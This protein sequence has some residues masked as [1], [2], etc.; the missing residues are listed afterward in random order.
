MAIFIIAAEDTQAKHNLAALLKELRGCETQRQFAKRLQ[1][2]YTSIQDWEKEIRLPSEKNLQRIAQLKGWTYLELVL[3]LFGNDA[4]SAIA[5]TDPLELIMS[6]L[7]KLSSA[8]RQNLEDSLTGNK[9]TQQEM[10]VDNPL[11]YQL[12]AQEKHK[13]HLLLRASLK[14]QD[15]LDAMIQSNI[16]PDLFTDI[17]LRDEESRL[18]TYQELKQLSSLCCQV[19]RWQDNQL[20]EVDYTQTYRGRTAELLQDLRSSIQLHHFLY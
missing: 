11:N 20:P 13:L 7:P 17:F 4:R 10:Y 16:E 8:Q 3:F 19:V 5:T 2:A 6:C 15:P 14:F 1:T 9:I 18:V 12:N